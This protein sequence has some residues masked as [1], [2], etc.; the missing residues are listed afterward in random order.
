MYVLEAGRSIL[1]SPFGHYYR[2]S[3]VRS[4]NKLISYKMKLIRK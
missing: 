2:L 1:P 4:P 3:L